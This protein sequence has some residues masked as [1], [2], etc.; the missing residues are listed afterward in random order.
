MSA[1]IISQAEATVEMIGRMSADSVLVQHGISWSDYEELLDAIGEASSLRIC[2]DEGTLQVMSPSSKHEHVAK[3]IERLVDLLSIRQ[4]TKVLFYGS[5][6]LKKQ[7]EQKGAEPD[8]CFYVQTADAVGTKEQIDFD[9]DP[10]PDVVVEIDIHHE[11][12]S[13]LPIYAAFGVPELWRYDGES[14]TIHHLLDGQY[15]LA[16]A[17][18]ALPILTSAVLTQFLA[19]SPKEDQYDI[20]LAFEEWLKRQER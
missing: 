3:L 13:K 9:T 15:V 20:V 5:A 19:R 10:P 11:S 4:R 14:L 7:S 17:S 2:Y 16:N 12:I 8:A 18:K 6:T 1:Q